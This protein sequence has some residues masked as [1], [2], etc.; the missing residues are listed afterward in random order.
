M[1][2]TQAGDGTRIHYVVAGRPDGEPLLM[3]QGLGADLRAWVLQRRALG[4][5]HRLLLVDNRGA[6]RSGCPP[7]PYDLEVM[8]D[9]AVAVL[10]AEGIGSAHVMGASM[11][12]VLAQIIAVRRPDRVRSLVLA[13][14][15]CRHLPWR[16]E[17]LEAWAR[18]ATERGM[19]ALGS[20]ALRWLVGPRHHRRFRLPIGVLAPVLLDTSPQAFADQVAAILAQSDDVRHELRTI[21]VPVL[22]VV[23]TQDILTPLADSEELVDSIPGA[24]LIIIGGAAHGLMIDRA[25]AFNS[26]VLGFLEGLSAT[27]TSPALR[28]A[29]A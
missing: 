6:G 11:G 23:G 8:A 21:S 19:G 17:L 13:C 7:G 24:E 15:A 25:G 9:D 12:G 20:R 4:R 1:P 10:D 14:T 5:H 3:I 27:E 28:A 22:V 16:R 2:F 29:T 18:L 26:A